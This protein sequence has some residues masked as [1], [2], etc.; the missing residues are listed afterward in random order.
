M[1]LVYDITYLIYVSCLEMVPVP[2]AARMGGSSTATPTV[3]GSRRCLALSL[4]PLFPPHGVRILANP[5][6]EF[7]PLRQE[8]RREGWRHVKISDERPLFGK[9]HLTLRRRRRLTY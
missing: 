2:A 4:G 8:G 7:Q 5:T 9:I 6:T 1:R 3:Y